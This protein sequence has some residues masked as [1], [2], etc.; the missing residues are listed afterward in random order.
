M[1][2][3]LLINSL[4]ERLTEIA[5]DIINENLDLSI[6]ENRRFFL[7]PDSVELLDRRWHQWGIITHTGMVK[8]SFEKE[9]PLYLEKW[10]FLEKVNRIF[11][12]KIDGTGKKDLLLIAIIL[13]DTGKF[14]INT[15][16]TKKDRSRFFSFRGHEKGSG[17]IIRGEKLYSLL[18]NEYN[19]TS[20]QIEYI[21][22]S[23]ELHFELGILRERAKSCKNGYSPEFLQTSLFKKK[24]EKIIRNSPL[25][26]WEIGVV[27]LADT[28]GKTD[29]RIC[30]HRDKEEIR[31]LKRKIKERN[32]DGNLIKSILQIPVNLEAVKRYFQLCSLKSL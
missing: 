28:L 16:R 18:R 30:D 12:E 32:L 2:I 29:M 21:A 11:D 25:F 6:K 5:R 20:K 4:Q 17:D 22:K 27:F 1:E 19:L 7:Y 13:H 23:A 3:N 15:I 9:I 24:A 10:G 31:K 8:K 26:K 14:K